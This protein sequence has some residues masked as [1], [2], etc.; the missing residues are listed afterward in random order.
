MTEEAEF[1]PLEI[2]SE[3]LLHVFRKICTTTRASAYL[4][5]LMEDSALLLLKNAQIATKPANRA[6]A[7]LLSIVQLVILDSFSSSLKIN[8]DFL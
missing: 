4:D 6:V 2:V 5:V 8:Q 3:S 1:G 7:Q